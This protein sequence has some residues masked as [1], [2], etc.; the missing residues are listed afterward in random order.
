MSNEDQERQAMSNENQYRWWWG[1]TPEPE[2]YEA[3]F[4]TREAV[5]AA[6]PQDQPGAKFTII[7]PRRMPLRDDFFDAERILQ[8]WHE[9]NEE[10]QDEEGGLQME[11][12]PAQRMELER[13]LA[14]TFAAWR[15]RHGLGR[16]WNLEDRHYEIVIPCP[17]AQP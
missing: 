12:T 16:A 8:H 6:L 14:T 13:D 1:Y 2:Q 5:I 4:P 7:E 15:T 3:D 9:H 17:G 11:P 10:A